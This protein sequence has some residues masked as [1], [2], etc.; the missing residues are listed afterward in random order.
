M[1]ERDAVIDPVLLGASALGFRLFRNNSGV[2][3]HQDGSVVRYGVANPGGSDCLGWSLF[4]VK[5]ADVGR[6]LA[7]FTAVECKTGHQRPTPEQR[8]F[9][10]VVN[11]AGGIALWGTD[12]AV[13]LGQLALRLK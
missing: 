8:R 12:P 10:Q 2:A 9:I 1:P 5:P 11:D 4:H 6:T 7:V 3:F 13:I